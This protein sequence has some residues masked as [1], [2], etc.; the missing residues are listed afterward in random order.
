MS[1]PRCHT[2]DQMAT[3]VELLQRV[4]LGLREG[5]APLEEQRPSAAQALLLLPPS[6]LALSLS[7]TEP[8]DSSS[9]KPNH[10]AT[11]Q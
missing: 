11:Q 7:C 1:V 4:A 8:T 10:L 6:I 3:C 2:D 9:R 5:G